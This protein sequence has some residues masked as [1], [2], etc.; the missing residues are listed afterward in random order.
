MNGG[1]LKKSKAERA[2]TVTVLQ[3]E[4]MLKDELIKD[5]QQKHPIRILWMEN[6]KSRASQSITKLPA[7]ASEHR[8]VRRGMERRGQH[9][10]VQRVACLRS[11]FR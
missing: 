1:Q 5:A 11:V 4:T 7:N 3:C 8:V 6:T 9:G 2:K 10:Q